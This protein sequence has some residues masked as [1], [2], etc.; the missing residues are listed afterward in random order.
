[1]ITIHKKMYYA[2]MIEKILLKFGDSI[3]DMIQNIFCK[4]S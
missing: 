1:M 2:G 3:Y 4:K